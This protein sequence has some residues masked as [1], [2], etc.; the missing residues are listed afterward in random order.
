MANRR[1]K[2]TLGDFA[3]AAIRVHEAIEDAQRIC[4]WASRSQLIEAAEALH[5]NTVVVKDAAKTVR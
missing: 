5:G 3:R 2:A 1:M 4:G